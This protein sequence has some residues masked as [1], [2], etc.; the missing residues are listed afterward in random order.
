MIKNVDELPTLKS[1][2]RQ[3]MDLIDNDTYLTKISNTIK[4][5]H[6]VSTDRGLCELRFFSVIGIS[7][8]EFEQALSC[9]SV[10]KK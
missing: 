9:L 1:S 8:N 3:I 5:D 10:N 4:R 6:S 7:Q 2:Y